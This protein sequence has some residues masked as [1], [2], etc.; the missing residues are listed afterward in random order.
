MGDQYR[1]FTTALQEN[2]VLNISVRTLVEDELERAVGG[3][4]G[5]ALV[6]R[7]LLRWVDGPSFALAGLSDVEEALELLADNPLERLRALLSG[8]AIAIDARL[9]QRALQYDQQLRDLLRQDQSGVLQVWYGRVLIN[10]GHC[11]M[12]AGEYHEA[13]RILADAA[14]W[15]MTNEGPNDEHDRRCHVALSLLAR[16]TAQLHLSGPDA[17]EKFLRMACDHM[18]EDAWKGMVV[19][20]LKARIALARRDFETAR[21]AGIALRDMG[22]ILSSVGN[23]I[24]AAVA[25]ELEDT[26]LFM[27]QI[28]EGL[29]AAVGSGD[30]PRVQELEALRL[31]IA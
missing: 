16:G 7:A 5:V 9:V 30:W 31:R 25:L 15:H 26:Q 18:P 2:T 19:D 29:R 23:E 6:C 22:G 13:D 27:Q 1:R 8:E 24:L 12:L 11:H 3:E 21:A 17:A 28:E 14:A 10:S 4:R 20:E